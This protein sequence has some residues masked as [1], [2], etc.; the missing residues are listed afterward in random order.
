VGVPGGA[1]SKEPAYQCRDAVSIPGVGRSPGEDPLATHSSSLAWRIP[2]TAEPGRLWSIGSQNWT[3]LKQLS[4]HA[5]GGRIC[6]GP[7]VVLSLCV[8]WSAAPVIGNGNPLQ[9]SCLE[10]P[11]DGGAWWAAI[12]RVAQ[13]R[14]QL[15][16]FSSSS[17]LSSW[18][19]ICC[20]CCS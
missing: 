2:W 14:T 7:F 3:Q 12:Y 4:M 18:R 5:Q 16:Q 17:S 13:S 8:I 10:N 1:S 19:V 6:P 20:C 9:C 15:K 11:R